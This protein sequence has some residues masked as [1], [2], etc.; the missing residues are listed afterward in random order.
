MRRAWG[1]VLMVS[2]VMAPCAQAGQPRT[3][4]GLFLRLAG[5]VA[6]ANTEVESGDESLEFS[7][8]GGD[9]NF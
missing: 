2:L 9:G 6:F 8:I 7:D 1:V 3:H 5:G 4:D